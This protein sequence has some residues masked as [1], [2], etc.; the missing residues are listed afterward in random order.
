[1]TGSRVFPFLLLAV[2]GSAAFSGNGGVT[3][4]ADDDSIQ[5][6]IDQ[7]KRKMGEPSDEPTPT[8]GMPDP[9]IESLKKKMRPEEKRNSQNPQPYIDALRRKHPEIY[10]P[11]SENSRNIEPYI[12]NEKAKIGPGDETSAIAD[13]KNGKSALKMKRPGKVKGAF[14]FRVGTLVSHNVTASGGIQQAPFSSLYGQNY[15]PDFTLLGEYQFFHDRKWGSLGAVFTA[16]VSYF[17]GFGSFQYPLTQPDGTPFPTLSQTQFSFYAIPVT[18]GVDYRFNLTNYIRPF[19]IVS[20]AAIGFFESRNDNVQGGNHHGYSKGLQ[21]SA[22]AAI[23][24]DFISRNTAWDLYQDE[25]IKHVYFTIE[26][27]RLMSFASNVNFTF[28]GLDVGVLF[29]F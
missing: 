14:G 2:V 10:G 27:D 5:P 11:P 17:H 19:A 21:T 6:Y 7:L 1:M 26:Y 23:L 8:P 16:G 9:F 29:E 12:E 24:A 3:A 22:G 18:A 20:P 28:S 25:G 15:A 13:V 4:R